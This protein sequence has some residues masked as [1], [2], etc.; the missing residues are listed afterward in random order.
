MRIVDFS[1][2]TIFLKFSDWQQD[3]SE[4]ELFHEE[5]RERNLTTRS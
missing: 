3:V 2:M 1:L 5:N 4:T